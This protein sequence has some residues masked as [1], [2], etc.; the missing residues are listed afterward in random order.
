VFRLQTVG[1]QLMGTKETGQPVA[2]AGLPRPVWWV[3]DWM[4]P[5]RGG[6]N[7]LVRIRGACRSAV[8]RGSAAGRVLR[9][10]VFQGRFSGE[11]FSD[12]VAVRFTDVTTCYP[13]QPSLGATAH[14]GVVRNRHKVGKRAR[15][16][17]QPAFRAKKL[18]GPRA[19]FRKV[20]WGAK[21]HWS[22]PLRFNPGS[23]PTR[24]VRGCADP[25]ASATGQ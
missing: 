23:S 4:P 21:E 15:P 5:R 9:P 11:R 25:S 2:E 1:G 20:L 16:T 8:G 3:R 10:R 12:G 7:P 17:Y 6:V 13:G 22:Q 19:V 24:A 18:N 14:D